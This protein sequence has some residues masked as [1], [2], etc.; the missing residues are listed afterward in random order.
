MDQVGAGAFC[1]MMPGMEVY[2]AR[3]TVA[4]E[5]YLVPAHG[6]AVAV[7]YGGRLRGAAPKPATGEEGGASVRPAV[8]AKYQA[9]TRRRRAGAGAR[10][11]VAADRGPRHEPL[12]FGVFDARLQISDLI[13]TTAHNDPSPSG[14][15]YEQHF[16]CGIPLVFGRSACYYDSL[17][18]PHLTAICFTDNAAR[19]P[20]GSHVCS[21]LPVADHMS[22]GP[23]LEKIVGYNYK[24]S[25][26][27]GGRRPRV[28][29]YPDRN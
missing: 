25:E 24:E 28:R 10:R 18:V 3:E 11:A 22:R 21:V 1:W 26:S 14:I 27:L 9:Q 12:R 16:H 8:Q 5:G 20:G 6:E 23:K 19:A 15:C 13:L 17:G 2:T 29:R 7:L 4:V